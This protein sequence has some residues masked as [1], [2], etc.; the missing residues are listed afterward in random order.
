MNFV[1]TRMSSLLFRHEFTALACILLRGVALEIAEQPM[2][3]PQGSHKDL[4]ILCV[5]SVLCGEYFFKSL[6][7]KS[8]NLWP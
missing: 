4:I 2:P 3:N 1:N 6:Q 7:C 8:K 5:L